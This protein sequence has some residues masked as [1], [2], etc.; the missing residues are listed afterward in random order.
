M[1]KPLIGPAIGAASGGK[2]LGGVVYHDFLPGDGIEISMAITPRCV[3][4]GTIRAVLHYPFAQL[5]CRW[6]LVRTPPDHKAALRLAEGV[7]F[8]RCGLMPEFYAPG[9]DAVLL[10][11]QARTYQRRYRVR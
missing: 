10:V 7:G 6:V 5:G 3:T 11:M 9:R 8:E 1:G 2:M 4:R